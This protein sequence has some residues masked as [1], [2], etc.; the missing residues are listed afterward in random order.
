MWRA[1]FV[2]QG[3]LGCILRA[4]V[5]IIPKTHCLLFLVSMCLVKAKALCVFVAMET[6]LNED[7]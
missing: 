2:G 4:L 1:T 7:G 6:M 5:T 3:P